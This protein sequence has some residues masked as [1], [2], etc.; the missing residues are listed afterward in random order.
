MDTWKWFSF[1]RLWIFFV[2]FCV[3]PSFIS[4]IYI[5]IYWYLHIRTHPQVFPFILTGNIFQKD[6]VDIFSLSIMGVPFV[7]RCLKNVFYILFI[8]D[9]KHTT[10]IVS[11][12]FPSFFLFLLDHSIIHTLCALT[13]FSGVLYYSFLPSNQPFIL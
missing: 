7:R 6:K 8:I 11:P 3:P 10:G 1:R 5:H 12:P 13:P 4:Y 9:L 2:F